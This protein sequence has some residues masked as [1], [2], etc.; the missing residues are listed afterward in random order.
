VSKLVTIP[1]CKPDFGTVERTYLERVMQ[2]GKLEGGGEFNRANEAWLESNCQC[3]RAMITPSCT[4]ALE[5]MTLI[6]DIQ[7]GDEVI[8]PGFTFVSTANAVALRGGVPVFVDIDPVTL[9]IDP[10]KAEAAISSR[11][12]AIM[13]VHYAGVGCDLGAFLDICERHDLLLL[14]DAA[15]GVGAK[16]DGRPLG[17]FGSLGALSFHHTKNITCGEGGALLINDAKLAAVAEKVQDKG[18]DRAE[19]RR[20]TRAKYEWMTLGSSFLLSELAAGVLLAQLE[21]AESRTLQR[22]KV[23]NRYDVEFSGL[24]EIL[25]PQIPDQAEHNGHIYHLRLPSFE[26]REALVAYCRQ[27]GIVAASHY[28]PLHDTPGGRKFGKASGSMQQTTLASD[29]LIRL[30]IYNNMTDEEQDFVISHVSKFLDQ[31]GLR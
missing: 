16:W 19:F 3:S 5:M 22:L 28:V 26:L 2:C 27:A 6:F 23:W 1:F 29:T 9:N 30:P 15:Q 21:A 11:T 13:V 8:M 18:T 14:E 4:A 25:T 7:P 17:S 12:R 31:A 20:G 24:S 10:A